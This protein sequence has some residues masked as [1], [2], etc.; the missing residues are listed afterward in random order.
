MEKLE[1][2]CISD[3]N[4]KWYRLWKTIC[5]LQTQKLNIELLYDPAI[6]LLG[7]YPKRTENK[8]SDTSM[9]MFIAVIFTIAKRGK[10]PNAQQQV[11]A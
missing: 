5:W 2:L 6:P 8:D 1:F 10:Q 11:N 9:P 4:I 7:I 3:R